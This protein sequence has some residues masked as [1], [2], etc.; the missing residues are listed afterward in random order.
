MNDSEKMRALLHRTATPPA[1]PLVTEEILTRARRKRAQGLAV[2]ASG[3]VVAVTATI[4]LGTVLRPIGTHEV[5]L[6]DDSP[7]VPAAEATIVLDDGRRRPAAEAA[8]VPDVVGLDLPTA[9]GL[10]DDFDVRGSVLAEYDWADPDGPDAVVVSQAP[11]AGTTVARQDVVG[12]RTAVVTPE[13]C[14]VLA[15]LTDH[16]GDAASLAAIPAFEATIRGASTT[17]GAELQADIDA[18]L[19][20]IATGG[21]DRRPVALALE[22]LTIHVRACS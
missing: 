16:D 6:L 11:P 14:A 2:K 13:L 1:S 3:V 19:D 12:L 18:V 22:R 4:A 20:G 21:L 17:A 8:I 7:T 10:L 15:P 9:L 5:A